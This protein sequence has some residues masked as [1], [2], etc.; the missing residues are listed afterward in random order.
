MRPSF[1]LISTVVIAAAGTTCALALPTTNPDVAVVQRADDT[2][3][4]FLSATF[5]GDVP[6]V[7]LKYST[8]AAPVTFSA[9]QG[10]QGVLVPTVGTGGARDP[11]IFHNQVNGKYYILAT[12]LDIGKTNWGDAQ[13]HGSRSIIVWESTDGVNW[14]NERLVQLM[15]ETAGYVWAPSATWDPAANAYAVFWSSQTYAA[16]DTD[17][18]GAAEG[19]FVYYSYTTDMVNFTSPQRWESANFGAKVIDQEVLDLGNGN[20]Y[21]WYSDV[22]GGTGVVMDKT[23]SGL[24]GTWERVGKP[25]DVVW[26]GPA[27]QRDIL[28]PSKFYLWEDNYGGAGYSCFQTED[29]SAI[30]FANCDPALTPGGMRHG[31]VVQVPATVLA[32]LESA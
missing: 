8:A 21:R 5:L 28:N 30:P 4:G 10:S 2:A 24:F 22:S 18:T 29:L 25:V 16:T 15:D 27:I 7:Y 26:E 31:A 23:S 12:D 14:T 1:A 3:A 13:S 9:V 19:P 20:M 6:H 32:A 11:Y 17:H